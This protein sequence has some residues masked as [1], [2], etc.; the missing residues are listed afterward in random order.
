VT[1]IDLGPITEELSELRR[2]V[3]RIEPPRAR[4]DPLVWVFAVV[5]VILAISL[6]FAAPTVFGAKQQAICESVERNTDTIRALVGPRPKPLALP[7]DPSLRSLVEEANARGTA[8]YDRVQRIL[9]RPAE[10]C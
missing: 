2:I 1:G 5:I 4:R 9:K 8:Q 10:G 7:D 6:G 3:A